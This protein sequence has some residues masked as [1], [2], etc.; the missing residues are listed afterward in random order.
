MFTGWIGLIFFVIIVGIVLYLAQ[1][2]L[3]KVPM[4]ATFKTIAWVLMVLVAVILV[5][6]KAWPLLNSVM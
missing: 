6:Q 3:A 5:V 1:L 4:D 2:L